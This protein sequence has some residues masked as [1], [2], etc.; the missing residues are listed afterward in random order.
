M[1]IKRRLVAG[2]V[3]RV[4]DI[5]R[6]EVYQVNVTPKHAVGSE[7]HHDKPT[8]WLIVS[9]DVVSRRFP[10]VLAAP[11]TSQVANHEKFREARIHLPLD[12][13]VKSKAMNHESL[14]LT[15]QIRV[16]SHERLV[17]GPIATLTDSAMAAVEAGLAYVLGIPT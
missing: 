6:G 2:G 16:L 1:E 14:V 3:I 7:Q 4:E 9:A 8:P 13:W 15:E 17:K 12:S 5:R 11:L 10:I